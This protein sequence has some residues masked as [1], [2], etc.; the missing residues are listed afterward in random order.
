ME[1][2]ERSLTA[3]VESVLVASQSGVFK[4]ASERYSDSQEDFDG[5][6]NLTLNN[7][8]RVYDFTLDELKLI[9]NNARIACTTN[10]VAKNVIKHKRNFIVGDGLLF[11]VVKTD[12]NDPIESAKTRRN[13]SKT[14]KLLENW[15][16]F[17]QRNKLHD[18]LLNS[19]ERWFRDGEFVWRL[20]DTAEGP[21][22]RFID[23]EA[24]RGTDPKSPLG[25][26]SKPGDVESVLGIWY[27]DPD[28]K[29][30]KI[31]IDK[32]ILAK[33]NVDFE[34]ERGV[35][36]FYPIF[37]N[38]RR[39]E[40]L[41]VNVSVLTQVQS[42]IALIRKH[43]VAS[44][45]QVTKFVNSLSDGVSRTDSVTRRQIN[46]RKYRAG[47]IIDA[48]KGVSYDFPAHSVDAKK[49]L[50]VCDKELQHVADN[51]VLPVEWLLSS[52]PTDP[53]SPGSPVVANFKTEQAEF[54]G[55]VEDLFWKV[56][57]LYGVNVESI[58]PKY[59]LLIS[60]PRLAVG[61]ALDEARVA[62]ILLQTG[63]SSPQN[64]ART[65]GV[66]YNISRADTIAH[67]ATLQPGEM[68]PGSI[69]A[70]TGQATDGVSKK[71]GG[72]K[73]DNAQ[74]GNNNA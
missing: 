14:K 61:K 71:D 19:V 35:S 11:E 2:I 33:N 15:R 22:L 67:Y 51:F 68:A 3:V 18:R 25:V 46:G 49:F 58:R 48:P 5:W 70:T 57:E 29:T 60:G 12:G 50:D 39:L 36:S 52:E 27:T 59:E 53:I 20:F 73:N 41:L 4:E 74:G 43:E 13:D 47:A 62:Q 6:L 72:T 37:T 32:I 69:G 65:F 55:Y 24:V 44:Q 7:N 63:A 8:S 17:S 56:Q 40:K 42:A 54:Y 16:D 66:D 1:R 45:A 31:G 28:N 38:L 21:V 23:P 34:T 26:I 30:T 10:E 64:I 9:R